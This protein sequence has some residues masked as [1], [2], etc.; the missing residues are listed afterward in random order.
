MVV[1]NIL[2]SK[3]SNTL[4]NQY[5]LFYIALSWGKI[6]VLNFK[7]STWIQLCMGSIDKQLYNVKEGF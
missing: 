7:M 6:N 2:F 5:V 3:L 4:Y 1:G